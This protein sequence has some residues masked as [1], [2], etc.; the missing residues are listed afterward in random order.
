MQGMDSV[1]IPRSIRFKLKK[2]F[3]HF[4]VVVVSGARQVGK[5]TLLE[6][7]FPDIHK[8]AF[9]PVVDIEGARS[10]PD[11]FLNNNPSPIILDE[12]Q[13]VP[14]L[15]PAIKRR[16]DKNK[17]NGQ[18]L[19]TGSQQW[20][21]MKKLS[22]SLAGRA[23]FI[24]LKGF[25]LSE[26]SGNA[27]ENFWVAKWLDSPE[28]II[29]HNLHLAN[30]KYTLF[31][32]IWRGFLPKTNFLPQDL[33]QDYMLAYE[34]TYIERDIRLMAEI[35]DLS[36]FSKFFRLTA[37]LTAK[38]INFSQMGR[39]LGVTPQTATRW[40]ELLKATFQWY[41]I[42]AY[43]G[44]TIKRLSGKPK[45]HISDTG[46]A[47]FCLGISLPN[48]L[49]THPMWGFIFES[50]VVNE[51][52]KQMGLFTARA[53]CYHW[54]TNGGAEVD[55]IIEKD[56]VFYPFEIKGNSHPDKKDA[57]GIIAFKKT[58]PKLDIKPGLIIAPSESFYAVAD[59]IFVMPWNAFI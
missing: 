16:V 14:E 54:R 13:Y 6:N 24:D 48:N 34:R 20:E 29:S 15:I 37:A 42:S 7:E 18:Y 19:V 56:G 21:V 53:N 8:I 47:C 57:G 31:E 51:I 33:I 26:I 35:S 28:F 55:L 3:E 23:V 39:E 32:Q 4:P 10:D 38:E 59:D 25:N 30:S 41:E 44:N 27:D 17:K 9:D 50:T 52:R 12:I 2:L 43:S 58:Y 22:E 46:L 11:L 36:L 49:S 40:L 5:S 1:Y 45:G